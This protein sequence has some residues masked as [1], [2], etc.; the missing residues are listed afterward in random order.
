MPGSHPPVVFVHGLWLHSSSWQPWID[1]FGEAGYEAT[2]PEWPGVPSTVEAARNQPEP[3]AGNGIATVVDHLAEVIGGLQE[4]PIVIGH[5]FGGL[6]AQLLLGRDLA[7]AA[8]A[9]SPAQIKGVLPLPVSQLRS[10]APILANPLNRRRAVSLTA[11]QFRYGFANAVSATESDELHAR[12]TIPS[13]ARP[14]FEA[15][16]GNFNPRSPAK[17]AVDNANRGPLLFLAA[18]QDHTV[19]A[20][21]T[22]AAF[23]RYRKSAAVTELLHVDR[24]HSLTVDSGWR[25]VARLTLDWLAGQKL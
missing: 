4:K 5:S 17:A 19:P 10:V 2:A 3:Q 25:E 1:L 7:A 11:K 9:I 12:W 23:R 8:V 21:V 18:K 20:V 13:P 16:A 14:L 15:A 6:F 22:R 24:G